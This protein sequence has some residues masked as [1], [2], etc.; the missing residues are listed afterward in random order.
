MIESGIEIKKSG[1]TAKAMNVGPVD[2]DLLGAVAR[3]AKLLDSAIESI[4]IDNEKLSVRQTV[5]FVRPNE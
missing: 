1:A 3:L 4:R 2:A 5:V